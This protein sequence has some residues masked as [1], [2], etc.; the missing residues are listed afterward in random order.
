[1]NRRS[2]KLRPRLKPKLRRLLSSG[3]MKERRLM[4]IKLRTV[5]TEPPPKQ[6]KLLNSKELTRTSPY[7]SETKMTSRKHSTRSFTKTS[8]VI[9]PTLSHGLISG[10]KEKLNSLVCC[11]FQKEPPMINLINFTKRNLKLSSMWRECWLMTSLKNFFPSISILWEA[12]LTQISFHSMWTD[13]IYNKATF[14]RRLDKLYWKK[15]LICLYLLTL[16][17]KMK[18]SYFQKTRKK[19]NNKQENSSRPMIKKLTSSINFGKIS[20]KTSSSAW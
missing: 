16:C 12:L 6:L 9:H 19:K 10:Q 4:K 17:P 20:T 13:K 1:M 15:L 11:M 7:G 8:S 18:K 3:R 5:L 14:S 2:R